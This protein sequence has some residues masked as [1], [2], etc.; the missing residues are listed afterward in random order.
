MGRGVCRE[1]LSHRM[2]RAG[3]TKRGLRAS[4]VAAHGAGEAVWRLL[5]PEKHGTGQYVSFHGSEVSDDRPNHR[6]LARQRSRFTHYY[7][8]IR[9]ERLGPMVPRV[10]S[11]FPFQATYYLNGHRFI[12]N[13]LNREGVKFRKDDNAFLSVSSPAALQTAADRFTAD[14]I[15]ERPDYWTLILGPEFSK[16]ERSSM[17]LRRFYAVSQIEYC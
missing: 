2:G 4:G 10:A 7:F 16:H 11:F 17:N 13:E 9:D 5:P 3:C 15:R 12:E 6:I 1:S 8:Y 14:T